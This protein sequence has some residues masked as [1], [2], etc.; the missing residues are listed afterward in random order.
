MLREILEVQNGYEY[1]D[2]SPRTISAPAHRPPYGTDGD[3]FTKPQSEDIFDVILKMMK[4][5][6]PGRFV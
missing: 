3:Y 1:L 2:T 4:E 5:Y 6:D